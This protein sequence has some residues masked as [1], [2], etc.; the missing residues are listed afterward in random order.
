MKP[1]IDPEVLKLLSAI[2]DHL[3]QVMQIREADVKPAIKR[4]KYIG[5]LIED[6]RKRID[7]IE[8]GQDGE[9]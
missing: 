7:E 4:I 1:K 8:R 9:H 5:G 3:Y 2:D 6:C